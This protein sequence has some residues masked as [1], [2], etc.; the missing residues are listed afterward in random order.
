MYNIKKKTKKK[1]EDNFPITL[2][3]PKYNNGFNLFLSFLLSLTKSII[4]I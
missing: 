4:L 2:N 3:E 1:F